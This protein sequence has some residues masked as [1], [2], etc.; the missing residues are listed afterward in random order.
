MAALFSD[1]G[2]LTGRLEVEFD[3]QINQRLLLQPRIESNVAAQEIPEL[4]IGSGVGSI[5]AGVRLRYEIRRNSHPIGVSAGNQSSGTPAIWLGPP[6]RTAAAG[7]R[8]S[9]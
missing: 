8:F 6:A 4:G 5:E 2:D 9:E 3:L 1:E 7:R